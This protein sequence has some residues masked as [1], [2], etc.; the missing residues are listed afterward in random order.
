MRSATEILSRIKSDKTDFFGFA[1]GALLEFLTF[2]EAQPFLKPD[3]KESDWTM[4]WDRSDEGVKSCMRDYMAFAW[5]KAGDHRGLSAGRS[6]EKMEAWIWLLE[7]DDFLAQL[8][9]VPYE[10]YG[11]PKLKAICERYGLDIPSDPAVLRMAAGQSCC[12]GCEEGCG[13]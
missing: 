11:A 5:G 2:G 6:I 1:T 9:Q 13:R 4:R 10:N 8:A 12:D 7:D 3:A